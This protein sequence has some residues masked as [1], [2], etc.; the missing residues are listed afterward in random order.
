MKR[1]YF[2]IHLIINQL[3]YKKAVKFSRKLSFLLRIYKGNPLI[4]MFGELN[5]A[6]LSIFNKKR[7]EF[8]KNLHFLEL[9]Y[10]N[11]FQKVFFCPWKIEIRLFLIDLFGLIKLH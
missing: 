8:A 5:R 6:I 7:T 2:F 9:S 11:T 1:V 10:D 3:S 4:S